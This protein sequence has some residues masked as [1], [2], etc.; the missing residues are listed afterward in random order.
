[1]K[2]ADDDALPSAETMLARAKADLASRT[3]AAEAEIEVVDAGSVTWPNSALGCPEE[4]AFYAQMLTEGYR[5]ILRVG[6]TTYVYHSGS[7]A[8]PKLCANPQKPLPGGPA[9]Q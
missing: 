7:D 1:M 9:I 8:M 2:M 5:A 6:E 3:S 4:G